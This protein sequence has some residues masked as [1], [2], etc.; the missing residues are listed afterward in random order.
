MNERITATG[1]VRD[2]AV[3]FG[4][5]EKFHGAYWH[6]YFLL[7]EQQNWLPFS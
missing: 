3:A 2:E 5:V 1:L 4:V 7:G 6:R